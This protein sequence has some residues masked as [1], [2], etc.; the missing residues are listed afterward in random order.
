MV[1]FSALSFLRWTA[2]SFFPRLSRR[3]IATNSSRS[4][5][6]RRVTMMSSWAAALHETLQHSF[7]VWFETMKVKWLFDEQ[8]KEKKVRIRLSLLN[9]IYNEND[10]VQSFQR[11]QRGRGFPWQS[12]TVFTDPSSSS[13]VSSASGPHPHGWT[14]VILSFDAFLVTDTSLIERK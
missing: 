9:Q 5:A 10:E 3:M 1:A 8:F 4:I 12:N 7:A 13:E 14:E 2:R 6:K 11:T